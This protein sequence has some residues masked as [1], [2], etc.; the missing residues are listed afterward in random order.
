MSYNVLRLS[1]N[2]PYGTVVG[3][4]PTKE[5]AEATRELMNNTTHSSQLSFFIVQEIK[6]LTKENT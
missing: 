4:Y 5:Q 1:T 6:D 2:D 3:N